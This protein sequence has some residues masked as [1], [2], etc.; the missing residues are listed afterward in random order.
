M[1]FHLSLS[2]SKSPQVSRTLLSILADLNNAVVWIVT[3]LLLTFTSSSCRINPLMTM[4]R[5]PIIIGVAV[6][7]LLHSFFNSLARSRYLYLF[8]F[9]FNFTVWSAGTAKSTIWQVF[10]S[11]YYYHY[12]SFCCWRN[13]MGNSSGE[14]ILH[15]GWRA[16]FWL[17]EK[18]PG[19][20][21]KPKGSPQIRRS[22]LQKKKTFIDTWILLL[23]W[24]GLYHYLNNQIALYCLLVS[25]DKHFSF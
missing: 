15:K 25:F 6:T 24:I 20:N 1:V 9:S 18:M 7:F 4:P 3:T 12:Y 2:D 14:R 5:G 21:T 8:S 10:F 22:H 17:F 16:I 23:I 11:C 19:Y 13:L